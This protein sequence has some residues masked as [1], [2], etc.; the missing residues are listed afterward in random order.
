MYDDE[1]RNV[2]YSFR[3]V[4]ITSCKTQIDFNKRFDHHRV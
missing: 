2:R 3:F 4:I 1:Q